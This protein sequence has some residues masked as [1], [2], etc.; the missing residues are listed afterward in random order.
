MKDHVTNREWIAFIQGI[1]AMLVIGFIFL[2]WLGIMIA[3]VICSSGS[4]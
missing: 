1:I 3:N 4:G 2:P